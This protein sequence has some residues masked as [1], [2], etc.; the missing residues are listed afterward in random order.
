MS[1]TL[2]APTTE[3]CYLPLPV[4]PEPTVNVL[5]S[6]FVKTGPGQYKRI[7]TTSF[8]AKIAA[9]VWADAIAANPFMYSLRPIRIECNEAK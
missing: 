4:S 9:Y 7:V 1:K 5:Y 6:L 2:R 3:V 8:K